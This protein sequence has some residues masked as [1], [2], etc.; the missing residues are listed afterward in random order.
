LFKEDQVTDSPDIA[1]L[2]DHFGPGGVERVACHLAN[3]LQRRGFRVEMVVVEDG[4]PIRDLLD[5]GV[6]VNQ[7]AA[8]SSARR[9]RRMK[10]AVPALA[11]YLRRRSPRVFHSPGNH[12]N[13]P[14]AIAVRLAGFTGA[15]VPKVTNPLDK[16]RGTRL[17]ALLRQSAFGWAFAKA[18]V[19]LTLSP[20]AAERIAE[21]DRRLGSRT[22]VVHNPY[23]SEAMI[24]NA[25]NR[26]P[27]DPPVILAMGRLSEQKNH[28]LLIRAAARLADR[29]WRLRI[30]GTGPQEEALRAL[31]SELGIADRLELPGFVDDPVPEYL[32]ATVMALSSRWEGLPATI[33]EALACGCPVISTASSDGLVELLREVGAR[34]PIALD[35]E[36]ALAD[37]LEAALDGDLPA[38]PTTAVLPYSIDAACDEHAALFAQLMAA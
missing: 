24:R 1:I 8:P 11:A 37:A 23:V 14:A 36:A 3:G 29:R 34:E 38:V 18:S 31:A 25:A 32:A 17:R 28:A 33:L 9:S 13:R 22:Q 20:S 16:E 15:F 19:V 26:N 4:G 21:L 27:V 30:C 12:T 2:L 35:D 6:S 10:A 5:P 7:L